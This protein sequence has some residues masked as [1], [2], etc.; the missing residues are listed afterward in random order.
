[1]E[2]IANERESETGLDSCG[3]IATRARILREDGH[4]GPA[5]AGE[6]PRHPQR[7]REILQDNTR[8]APEGENPAHGAGKEVWTD[9]NPAPVHEHFIYLIYTPTMTNESTHVPSRSRHFGGNHVRPTR[10]SPKV[11]R[12]LE[13]KSGPDHPFS[14]AR[15]PIKEMISRPEGRG[16]NSTNTLTNTTTEPTHKI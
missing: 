7:N 12:Y 8:F 6:R 16:K 2:E 3:K 4:A 10:F 14:L 9:K 11:R 15:S 5:P 1:M 13:R